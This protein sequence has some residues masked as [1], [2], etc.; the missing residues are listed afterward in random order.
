[1]KPIKV[2]LCLLWALFFV[3]FVGIECTAKELSTPQVSALIRP[4]ESLAIQ[5]GTGDIKAYIFLDPKCPHSRDF[6]SMIHDND[7]MRSIYRYYIFFYELKR[8]HSHDLIGTI[9]A[10]QAPLQQTLGVMVGEKEIEELR[11]FPAKVNERIE[12]IA[13][14]A[15]AIG[16][17]KRPYLILKKELD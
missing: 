8:L 12:A 14:V 5:Y 11:S 9:Y 2:Q 4:I 1:M 6:L 7:K 15:E 17:N 10:S 16:V 13:A 3:T